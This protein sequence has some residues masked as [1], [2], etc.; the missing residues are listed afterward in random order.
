M[1]KY[2]LEDRKDFASELKTLIMH[3]IFNTGRM[4]IADISRETLTSIPTA[5]KFINELIDRGYVLEL[6]KVNTSGGRK[7]SIYGVNPGAGYFVGADLRTTYMNLSIVDF[8]GNQ[9]RFTRHVP[10]RLTASTK[11][12]NSLKDIIQSEVSAAGIDWDKIL[13]VGI[14]VAGPT[15]PKLG[16]NMYYYV[17][18]EE[19][20]SRYMSKILKVPVVLENVSR[21]KIAAEV[22]YGEH[23]SGNMIFLNIDREFGMSY[24]VDYNLIYGHN[25][26]AGNAGHAR[27]PN[28]PL[29][30]TCGKRGCLTTIASGEAV[31]RLYLEGLKNGFACSLSDK[32]SAGEEITYED[33]WKALKNSDPLAIECTKAVGK[34]LVKILSTT[35]NMANPNIIIVGGQMSESGEAMLEVL[36]EG[37]SMEIDQIMYED[38]EIHLTSVGERGASLGACIMAQRDF[39]GM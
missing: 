37:I 33:V 20:F 14:S 5:T 16:R 35:I 15:D 32:Y 11:A 9:V 13:H 23:L 39:L 19:P 31:H 8:D 6:G 28:N 3:K 7:P 30:C 18:Q 27:I 2:Y 26:F 1:P 21:A 4:T 17:S 24:I 29:K 34:N 36:R 10:F 22:R 38:V 12:A 25:G